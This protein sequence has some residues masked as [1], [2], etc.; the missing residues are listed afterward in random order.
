MEEVSHHCGIWVA[1]TL[2]D[3]HNFGKSLQNRG[4]DTMGIVARGHDRIDA[5]KWIGDTDQFDIFDLHKIFPSE[6]Y[7]T[8]L[9]HVRYATQGA[10]ESGMEMLLQEAHPHVIGG[11]A[12]YRGNHIIIRDCDAALVHNG[13]VDAA[14]LKEVPQESLKTKCDTEALLWFYHLFGE[15]E[16]LRRIP[17]AYALAI[18]DKRKKDVIVMRD[19]HGIRPGVL[20]LKDGKFCAASE[21]IALLEN[22]GHFY[23]DLSLG[24]VYYIEPEGMYHTEEIIPQQPRHCFF[25]WNYIAHTHALQ[26]EVSVRI[27]RMRLGEALAEEFRPDDANLVTFLP[28]CPEMAA[29]AYARKTK[30]RFSPVFYKMKS[31]RAFQ[32]PTTH[33]RKASIQNNLYL[34]DEALPL[35]RDKTLILI[36][37]SLVRGNNAQHARRLLT[38]QGGAKK[39]YLANYTPPLGII[40]DDG[41]PRGCLFGVDMPPEESK[42]HSFIARN[43]TLQEISEITGMN[44]VYLSMEKM[45][46][47]FESLGLPRNKL[48]TYCIG[49]KHPFE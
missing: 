6:H 49:G 16:L 25:E 44:V 20:G 39:V 9:G 42:H 1:H 41:A 21:D 10:K 12:E 43:R 19:R 17:G 11:T 26:N 4:R 38:E 14:F 22:G 29:I 40:G 7:H 35:V 47:T 33:E 24:S 30:L 48:C 8:Y 36:D 32:G 15:K 13:Q 2:H 3:C 45:L 18:A 23:E 5:L 31:E 28:R 34:M 27:L 37:D 46:Q